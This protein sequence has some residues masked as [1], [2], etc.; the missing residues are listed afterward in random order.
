MKIIRFL[1]IYFRDRLP[2]RKQ[3]MHSDVLLDCRIQIVVHLT[4]RQAVL[5]LSHEGFAGHMGVRKTYNR[6]LSKFYWPKVKRDVTSYI[7]SCHTCQMTGKTNRTIER[8]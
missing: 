3:S 6:I 7:R 8:T 1:S 4:F 2:R 5:Q